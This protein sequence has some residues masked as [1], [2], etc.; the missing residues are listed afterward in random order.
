MTSKDNKLGIGERAQAELPGPGKY[1]LQSTIG[2]FGSMYQDSLSYSVSRVRSPRAAE[3]GAA[4]IG[5]GPGSYEVDAAAVQKRIQC[6]GFR[7][8]SRG[9]IDKPKKKPDRAPFSIVEPDVDN[10]QFDRPPNHSFG[11]EAR[12]LKIPGAAAESREKVDKKSPRPVGPEKYNPDSWKAARNTTPTF[13]FQARREKPTDKD[14]KSVGP[15]SYNIRQYE[16]ENMKSDASRAERISPKC[17]KS[18]AP[19]PGQYE[20]ATDFKGHSVAVSGPV[21]TMMEKKVVDVTLW[22]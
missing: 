12:A 19:G 20:V 9:L 13:S 18:S 8:S 2:S 17:K 10:P 3:T 14:M 16:A 6:Y 11:I 22:A 5:T 15:A 21:W 7:G 4:I 1:D